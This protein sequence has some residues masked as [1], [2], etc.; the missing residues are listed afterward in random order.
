MEKAVICGSEEPLD[1]GRANFLA[2]PEARG[3]TILTMGLGQERGATKSRARRPPSERPS[4]KHIAQSTGFS[5]TTV[6]AVLGGRADRLGIAAGTRAK[7]LA[8]AK[9]L[10]Y[11]PNLHARSLRSRTTTLVG[12]MVPT[13]GN[14]F[15]SEMAETFESVA[16][17]GGML[18][19]ITVTNYDRGEEV[20]SLKYY[21]SQQVQCVFN[22]NPT[23]IEELTEL[24]RSTGTQQILLDAPDTG[25][26]TVATDSYQASLVLT[27]VTLDAIAAE[28]R[29]GR[30]YFLGG[31]ADHEVTKLRLAGFRAALK[32]KGIRYSDELFLD[33]PFNA[34]AAYRRVALLFRSHDDVAGMYVNSL[35]PMD[36]LVRFFGEHP[37]TC[38]PVHYAVFDHHPMMDLLVDLHFAAVRQNPELMMQRAWEIFAE[39]AAQHPQRIQYVPYELVVAPT[40]RRFLPQPPRLALR[41]GR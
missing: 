38:R 4:L 17:T 12:L 27:R 41:R 20:E 33:T 15:F 40:M 24:C 30:V 14:R 5:I 8:V 21:L 29:R 11:R 35:L 34:E 22:A 10:D 1:P 9:E 16:R 18:P 28:K 23:G 37:D 31:M 13:L 19:L 3:T 39:P 6:S 32:E 26:H 2:G 36:G 25:A 7:I